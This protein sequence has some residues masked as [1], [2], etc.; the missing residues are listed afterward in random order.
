MGNFKDIIQAEGIKNINLVDYEKERPWDFGNNILYMLCALHPWHTEDSVIIAKTNIIGR[1]YAVQ[2]ER[3]KNRNRGNNYLSSENYYKD[4]IA[5]V[6]RE[7]EIDRFLKNVIKM[8]CST[9]SNKDII[10]I[11]KVHKVL[12][13]NIKKCSDIGINAVSF[14]SKYLHFHLP[15]L[16]FMYDYRA[17]ETIEKI[18]TDIS[19]FEDII[20]ENKDNIEKVYAK[21][22]YRCVKLK[23]ALEE[24]YDSIVT[25]RM[26]DN[27]LLD[28]YIPKEIKQKPFKL[29]I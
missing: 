22:F 2:L 19:E 21:F 9:S 7:S 5:K 16:F 29:T 27:I 20:K 15:N 11:L 4:I 6:F 13:Y 1:V 10:E 14:C 8:N 18:V 3:N 25:P 23:N 12:Q 28:N 17:S 24:K 26:I